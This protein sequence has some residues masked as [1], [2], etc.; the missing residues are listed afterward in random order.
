[1]EHGTVSMSNSLLKEKNQNKVAKENWSKRELI[2]EYKSKSN[3]KDQIS[4]SKQ[5]NHGLRLNKEV[6]RKHKISHLGN[7]HQCEI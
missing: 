2:T 5:S 4:T 3:L 7:F 6:P 1:M